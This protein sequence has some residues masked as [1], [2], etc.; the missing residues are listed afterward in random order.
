MT[1]RNAHIRL[2]AFDVI[3]SVPMA[4]EHDPEDESDED[5]VGQGE[6]EDEDY[7]GVAE[8]RRQKRKSIFVD[9]AAEDDGDAVSVFISK[10]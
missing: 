2:P 9:D 8:S 6:D 5:F 1:P 10:Q 7:D 4:K 3:G